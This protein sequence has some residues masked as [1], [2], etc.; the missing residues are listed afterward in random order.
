M[1]LGGVRGVAAVEPRK[2][3]GLRGMLGLE[4][5]SALLSCALLIYGA[6]LLTFTI[7]LCQVLLDGNFAHAL[8]QMK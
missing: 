3:R 8:D 6:P 2:H 4:V 1:S 5:L 7:S